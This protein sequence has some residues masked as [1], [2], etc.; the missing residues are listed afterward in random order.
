MPRLIQKFE[1][2]SQVIDVTG[3]ID[4]DW[5]ADAVTRG[6][7][8]GVACAIATHTAKTMPS[9]Q[10][11]TVFSSSE[12]ELFVLT[13]RAFQSVGCIS[14]VAGFGANFGARLMIVARTVFGHCA[15]KGFWHISQHRSSVVLVAR[16]S[17]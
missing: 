5:V 16:A 11:V 17:A 9:T 13:K 10:Q 7:A 3:R 6:S 1:W 14:L 15:T 12:V 2:L 4:S 8:I